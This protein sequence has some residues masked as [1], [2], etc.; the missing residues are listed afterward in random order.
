MDLFCFGFAFVNMLWCD[1]A[2]LCYAYSECGLCV[3]CVERIDRD[4]VVHI[5]Y[6]GTT[7][8]HTRFVTAVEQRYCADHS[9][10]SRYDLLCFMPCL[11]KREADAMLMLLTE[12]DAAFPGG[13]GRKS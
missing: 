3:Q 7:A 11:W 12:H 9:K 10:P 2:L 13:W 1:V 4:K 5:Y 8:D 6:Y